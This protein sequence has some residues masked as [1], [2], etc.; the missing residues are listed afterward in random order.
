MKYIKSFFGAGAASL[1][2]IPS[3]AQQAHKQPN[4]IWIST[5]DLSP[6]MGCYGDPVAKTP[7]IDRLAS[8]GIRYKCI[9]NSCHQRSRTGRNYNRYVCHINRLNAYEDHLL[10]TVCGQ[11]S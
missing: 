2:F 1:L 6:H 3:L 5:E 4:I 11:S 10:Q 9:Y 7:N 8:Q